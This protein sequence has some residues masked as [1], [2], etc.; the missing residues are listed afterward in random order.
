MIFCRVILTG[1]RYANRIILHQ[2]V[3]TFG[4]LTFN[5]ILFSRR[6]GWRQSFFL[7]FRKEEFCWL[8]LCACSTRGVAPACYRSTCSR[9]IHLIT[10]GWDQDKAVGPCPWARN[11]G[12][13]LCDMRFSSAVVYKVS[14]EYSKPLYNGSHSQNDTGDN[15]IILV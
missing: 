3:V 2:K 15:W 11:L 4:E 1:Y 10:R 6:M 5:Q 8:A 9:K 14:A 13:L 7:Q 12:Q